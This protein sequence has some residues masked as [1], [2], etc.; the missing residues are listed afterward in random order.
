M[1]LVLRRTQH[2]PDGIFGEL[3]DTKGE[4]MAYTLEHSYVSGAGWEPKIPVGT[5]RCQRG[6]HR[7]H[8]MREPFETFEVIGVSG[9][10]N[11]LI[12]WGNFNNDSQ[13]C[14]LLG[15]AL[16][17]SLRGEMVLHSRV[18][19]AR[20]MKAQSGCSEFSLSVFG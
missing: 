3:F 12:H 2:R 7:L 9:R 18:T 11:L 8:G 5:Y 17:P 20:F 14:I 6:T 4:L 13:G 16:S 1:D 15:D 19:F 10:T